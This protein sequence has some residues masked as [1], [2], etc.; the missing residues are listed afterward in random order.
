MKIHVVLRA[1]RACIPRMV[2][3]III[4]L[5]NT[6]MVYKEQH[7]CVE[8]PAWN[9]TFEDSLHEFHYFSILCMVIL[10]WLELCN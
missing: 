1:G 9:V 3:L 10:I 2:F 7:F 8:V 6:W 5:I 4:W